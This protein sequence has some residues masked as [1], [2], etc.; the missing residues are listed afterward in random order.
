[1]GATLTRRTGQEAV[2]RARVLLSS[3]QGPIMS[4]RFTSSAWSLFM[5]LVTGLAGACGASRSAPPPSGVA[6]RDGAVPPSPEASSPAPESS[7]S[8][9]LPADEREVTFP[10]DMQAWAGST[11]PR[12]ALPLAAPMLF[13]SIGSALR[14]PD[15]QRHS[16][17]TEWPR[18]R[19]QSGESLFPAGD[20]R[21]RQD[22]VLDAGLLRRG[23]RRLGHV[24]HVLGNGDRSNWTGSVHL[25]GENPATTK[26]LWAGSCGPRLPTSPTPR[27]SRSTTTSFTRCARPPHHRATY[28]RRPVRAGDGIDMVAKPGNISGV[29]INEMVIQNLKEVGGPSGI[30]QTSPTTRSARAT[31]RA[32]CPRCSHH[33]REPRSHRLRV[34]DARCSQR[35]GLVDR[36]S[37]FDDCNIGVT[38]SHGGNGIFPGMPKSPLFLGEAAEAGASRSPM[39]V[40][41][42]PV[43]RH[44]RRYECPG[45]SYPSLR[46]GRSSRCSTP[47]SLRETLWSRPRA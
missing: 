14:G 16:V 21:H 27:T 1:M 20:L 45:S 9:P 40:P 23:S 47:S 25:S 39:R 26:I 2:G 35:G 46:T 42:L 33:Q 37:V 6:D 30:G 19:H 36:D 18:D 28:A 31:A 7:T 4:C 13:P 44:S 8:R 17:S 5:A 12:E 38:N 29:S 15:H 24:P 41:K 32:W 43:G 34:R 3:W 10:S 22:A 11:S